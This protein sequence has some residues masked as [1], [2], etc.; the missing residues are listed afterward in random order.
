MNTNMNIMDTTEIQGEEEMEVKDILVI[1]PGSTSTKIA[2]F[3]DKNK[4]VIFEE[5]IVHDDEKINE[6]P[7]IASQKN[8][9]KDMVLELLRKNFYDLRNLSAVVGRGGMAQELS[10]GGYKVNQKLCNRMASPDIPQHASSLG[11]LI[12]YAVAEP[13]NIPAYIYD[14]PMG[15]DLAD[16]AKITGIA[17][18]EKYGATHLLN[19]RAQAI[20]LAE[21][22][23]RDYKELQFIVCHMGGGITANAWKDGK[24]ID[25]AGYDDGAMAPERSGGVPLLLYRKLCFDGQHTEKE[26]ASL[27]SGRGGL[28]SYLGTKDCRDVEK[29]IAEGD[30]YAAL[31][32]EAMA[33]QVGKAVASLSCILKG[34]VD[35]IILTGGIAHSSMLTDMIK[36]FCGHI[37]DIYVMAGESEMEALADGAMRMLTGEEAYSEY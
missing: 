2:I 21:S 20:K 11:A 13:L 33:L 24:V 36:D 1:N 25:V 19:S 22:M 7:N 10:G 8:Y 26:M 18:I 12:A 4:E 14:S 15:C 5:N 29:M 3:S 17:E 35:F 6:F 23:G 30:D 16:T 9:R 34:K 28:Y 31:V 37:A 32:Y 27:I